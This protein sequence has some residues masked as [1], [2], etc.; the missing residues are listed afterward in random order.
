[1]LQFSPQDAAGL[2][3]L[4]AAEFRQQSSKIT[5]RNISGTEKSLLLENL[6]RYLDGRL[7][8]AEKYTGTTLDKNEL[9]KA[10][11]SCCEVVSGSADFAATALQ[12]EAASLI[13]VRL[14]PTPFSLADI[15]PA[16]RKSF[17]VSR[18]LYALFDGVVLPTLETNIEDMFDFAG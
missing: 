12:K 17:R 3:A 8:S 7:I 14:K 13:P 5:A 10:Y 6:Y 16:E 1:M 18:L 2:P 4:A 15:P 11:H 9:A